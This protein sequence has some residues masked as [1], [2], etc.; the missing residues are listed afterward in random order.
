MT[1]YRDGKAIE[2]TQQEL[3]DAYDKYATDGAKEDIK[4]TAENMDVD[5][6]EEVLDELAHRLDNVVGND[7]GYWDSYWCDVEYVIREYLKERGIKLC[8]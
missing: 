3:R 6:P 5:I 8:N 2:L 1:I 4:T 7:D